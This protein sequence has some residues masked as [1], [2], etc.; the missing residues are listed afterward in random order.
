[1]GANPEHLVRQMDMIPLAALEKQITIVGA[2][3]VGGVA[4][5][6]L[7]KMGF[8]GQIVYDFD[9]IDTVNMNCQMYK[10]KQIGMS[11]VEALNEIIE[12]YTGHGLMDFHNRA[13]EEDDTFSTEIVCV[14]VDSISVRKN[15][16]KSFMASPKARY[17]IDTRMAIE[18]G[19]VMVI[20][21]WNKDLLKMYT[22]SLHDESES[23]QQRCT[24]KSVMYTSGIIA[25]ILCK[26]VKDIAVGNKVFSKCV[27]DIANNDVMF[28]GV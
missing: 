5:L 2:G 18:F 14:P 10:V 7:A 22:S 4:S 16:F 23:V 12:D 15:L 1:M 19:E 28:F 21:K 9:T 3:A 24:N 25:G 26:A 11:K 17:L 8:A 20:D 27:Y 6:F 13:F